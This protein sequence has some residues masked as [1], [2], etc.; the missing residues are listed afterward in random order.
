MSQQF[1]MRGAIDLGALARRQQAAATEPPLPEAA[2]AVVREVTE[3][4]FERDVVQMSMTVPVVIDL[5][6]DWCGPCKQLSPILTQLAVADEG[7]WLLAK[8]DVDAEQRIAAAFQ[9]QSI[10]SVFAVIKGQP[11]P[12]FQGALPAPQVRRYLDEL[13]RL[14]AEQGLTGRVPGAQ[15]ATDEV[16]A[17]VAAPPEPPLDPRLAAAYA[18]IEAG[19]WDAAAA[20]YRELLSANPGDVEARLGL[21]QVELMRRTEGRDLEAD[22]SA[23]DAAP[24][25]VALALAA[26]DAEVSLGRPAAAFDRLIAA[27]R[28][29]SGQ[30]R[31]D[32]R[33]RLLELFELVGE[34]PEVAQ[35]RPKL[36]AALF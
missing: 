32:V 33:V 29:T 10:P 31:N 17:E 15:E 22:V 20:A 16:L 7:R 27:V 28:S 11:L 26:A 35:A 4:T 1:S 2:A 25:D 5:W 8:I 13:L 9:V 30:E 19:D 36:A 23:A 24:A 18:A 21:A 34:T 3:A 12:L 6:A 14:A